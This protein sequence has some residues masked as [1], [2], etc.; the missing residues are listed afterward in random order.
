LVQG[1]NA[2]VQRLASLSD[3]AAR[4]LLATR[5]GHVADD[6]LV[7][8]ALRL[9]AG[10]P[11]QLEQ[12]AEAAARGNGV[13][14]FAEVQSA[15]VREDLL[16]T[17]FA[18]LPAAGMRYAQAASVLGTRFRP[19]AA[20]AV[21]W[22]ADA[23]TSEAL[24]CLYRSG[25]AVDASGGCSRFVHPLFA[26]ALYGDLAIPVRTLLHR[27][28]FGALVGLGLEAEAA[29]HALPSDLG[30][31]SD[32]V[33]VPHRTGTT[34]LR[35]G[36]LATA[37]PAPGGGG[38]AGRRP[39]R[40]A[41]APHL[42]RDPARDGPRSGGDRRL[43][44]GARIEGSSARVQIETLRMLARAQFAVGTHQTVRSQ[45]AHAV[46][47][48]ETDF[49]STA[50]EVQLD[51]AVASRLT[52]DP[53]RSS[54]LIARARGLGDRLDVGT[55][56]RIGVLYGG[57]SCRPVMLSLVRWRPACGRSRRIR[58]AGYPAEAGASLTRLAGWNTTKPDRY[59]GG[60]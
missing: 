37:R 22:L 14:K 10:N 7:D 51:D 46:E 24:E 16:L 21:A 32:V 40:F 2:E 34:A 44:A 58:S 28:A 53:A 47:L 45:F 9:S 35:A 25:L 50:A 19:E 49:P 26:G 18:G 54:R 52:A 59:A 3:S 57:R 31:D 56:R 42:G 55:R 13:S 5:L 15:E 17:R 36:A 11:L 23:E 38:G 48:A 12:V 29:E 39:R 20:V 27:R 30:G 6:R 33:G 1:G 8:D 4:S 60:R 43:R 41:T